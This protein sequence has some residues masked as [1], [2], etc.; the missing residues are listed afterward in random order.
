LK[1]VSTHFRLTR[2]TLA[3]SSSSR[4]LEALESI[5]NLAAAAAAQRAKVSEYDSC[6]CAFPYHLKLEQIG[7]G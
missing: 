1:S 6:S 5:A 4:N 3:G 2:V 7:G